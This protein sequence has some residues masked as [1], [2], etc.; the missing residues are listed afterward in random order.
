[1]A[2]AVFD[3]DETLASLNTIHYFLMTLKPETTFA[4]GEFNPEIFTAD[5][6]NL[7]NSCY[8][9]FVREILNLELSRLNPLGL[10]RPGILYIM[11][12]LYELQKEG[13]IKNVVIYSNNGHLS[14]LELIRDIIHEYLGTN[15][16]I[17][18]CINWYTPGREDEYDDPKRPGGASKTWAVLK[19]LLVYGP[20][21]APETIEP[22]DIYF[23]DDQSHKLKNELPPGHY[24]QVTPYNYLVP[25]AIFANIFRKCTQYYGIYGNKD[26]EKS[27]YSAFGYK[28]VNQNNHTESYIHY[29]KSFQKRNGTT[30]LVYDKGILNINNTITKIQ[31]NSL[32]SKNNT[33]MTSLKG[34]KRTRRRRK[35]QKKSR[36]NNRS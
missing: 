16:L 31:E 6:K 26:I 12:K 11:E 30:P 21:K 35:H 2:Y 3:L 24:I 33:E 4:P 7:L 28:P 25:F 9:L 17:C 29:I 10:I 1:M 8:T 15:E 18:D 19:K 14:N 20:C 34:G 36:R 32:V 13:K 5:I 27:I 23:F 22:K